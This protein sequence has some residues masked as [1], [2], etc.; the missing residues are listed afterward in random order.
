MLKFDTRAKNALDIAQQVAQ[1]LNHN[2]IGSDHLIY[3]ILSQ[4]QNDL[5]FQM[6]FIDGLSNAELLEVIR[7]VGIETMKEHS[8]E[9]DEEVNSGTVFFPK[10]TEELQSCL[11]KAIRIAETYNFSYIGLEH[12]IFGIFDTSSSHGQ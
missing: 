10:I 3:G 6:A 4:P 5:P 1:D 2:Y 9:K 8:K 12:L 7:R 11:D